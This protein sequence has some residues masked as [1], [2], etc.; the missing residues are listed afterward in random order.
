MFKIDQS[1]ERYAEYPSL[2]SHKNGQAQDTGTGVPHEY[3]VWS[4]CSALCMVCLR[5]HEAQGLNWNNELE[6]HT[7]HELDPSRVEPRYGCPGRPAGEEA[8]GIGDS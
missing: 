5:G 6:K 1:K 8:L 4:L 2:N 3:A 7:Y